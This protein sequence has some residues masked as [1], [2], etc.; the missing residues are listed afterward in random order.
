MIDTDQLSK[1]KQFKAKL[2]EKKYLFK[3]FDLTEDLFNML[4]THLHDYAEKW[5][6]HD[7]T[8]KTDVK[9]AP[10]QLPNRQVNDVGIMELRDIIKE[11]SDTISEL[12]AT[13][14][15]VSESLTDKL[16]FQTDRLKN[17]SQICFS[18][19]ELESLLISSSDEA[20]SAYEEYAK[21]NALIIPSSSEE[22]YQ[23]TRLT[24]D[25]Y[26]LLPREWEQEREA[27]HELFDTIK[28]T[29]VSAQEHREAISNVPRMTT[30][31]AR[32]VR[33]AL[34]C[35]DQII[36]I[37]STAIKITENVIGE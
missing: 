23:L 33:K 30:K 6:N 9:I 12:M 21:S 4:V 35:N 15:I 19:E 26:I 27:I 7:Q 3:E 32:S 2:S 10:V 11:K 17:F 8:Q 20:A 24:V 25:Y 13:L 22:L 28:K 1:V 29:Q 31:L 5:G 18:E 36:D 16:N 37:F 14:T 34:Y